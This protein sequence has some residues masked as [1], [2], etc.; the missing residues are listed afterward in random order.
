M[1]RRARFTID[2]GIY[3]VMVRG[4]N[5][6]EIFHDEEDF[7][8]F[9]VRMSYIKN[10][11]NL[12]IYHYVLMDNHVHIIMQVPERDDL[13]KAIKALNLGYSQ[14]YRKKYGGIGHFFQDRFKSYVIQK[15]KY[16]LECGRY[17]EMNPVAAGMVKRPLDYNW[18]SYGKYMGKKDDLVSYDPEYLSLGKT[19]KVR[20]KLYK[21]F[22]EEGQEE[23]R[24]EDRFFRVGA[25]GNKKFIK[26]MMDKGLKPKW[27]KRGRPKK[28]D[29][30]K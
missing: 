8:Y 29:V 23:K 17:I 27:S 10:E 21:E 11:Y 15:G 18:S 20:R 1:P 12:D 30:K 7:K 4:N 9:K 24:S 25:Y 26:D 22:V 5:R 2:N 14:Y 6:N 3:H 19:D 16:L 13:S 28:K